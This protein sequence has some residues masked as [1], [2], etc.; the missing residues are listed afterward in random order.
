[1]ECI[2]APE[3]VQKAIEDYGSLESTGWKAADG[4]A[5][6]PAN[7]QGHFYRKMLENF[8]ALG[9]GRIYRYWF[10]EKVVAMDLCV[11][12]DNVIVILKTAYDESYKAISPSTLMRQD[13]FQHLFEEQKFTRIEFFGKV[14]EWHTRWSTQ[15]RTIFHATGYRWAWLKRLHARLPTSTEQQHKALTSTSKN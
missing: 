13:E 1:M 4:T 11:H 7:A 6:L 3:D 8:C 10:G 2:T 14:M 15:S 5:I 12:D 9:R